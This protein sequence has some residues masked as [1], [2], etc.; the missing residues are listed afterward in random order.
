MDFVMSISDQVIGLDYWRKDRCGGARVIQR[1][2][3]VRAAYLGVEAEHTVAPAPGLSD[4]R[5]VRSRS[6]SSTGSPFPTVQS[7]QSPSV[8]RR[9]GRSDRGDRRSN[10]AGDTS[11]LSAIAGLSR[12]LQAAF[13]SRG[14]NFSRLSAAP[15]AS[16]RA[17]PLSSEK[18][19][20]CR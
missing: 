11:L 17:L 7:S 2:A 8:D 12:P 20:R 1:N 4:A 18:G 5:G 13:A 19:G 10:R 14:G 9:R 15:S 3:R 16:R 6:F